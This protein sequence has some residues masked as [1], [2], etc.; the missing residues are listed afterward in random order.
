MLTEGNRAICCRRRAVAIPGQRLLSSVRL[1]VHRGLPLAAPTGVRA[2]VP[3]MPT[4]QYGNGAD[5]CI[6]GWTSV[7]ATACDAT[8]GPAPVIAESASP[9]DQLASFRPDTRL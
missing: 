4:K 7:P 3:A 5:R 9:R 6:Q 2:V 8:P 1:E